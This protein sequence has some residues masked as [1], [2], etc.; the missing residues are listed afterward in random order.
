MT[1][2]TKK[3]VQKQVD[4]LTKQVGDLTKRRGELAG[5]RSKAQESYEQRMRLM[6]S[7]ALSGK[8]SGG[9]PEALIRDRVSI[10]TLDEA[11]NQAD[12]KLSELNQELADKKAALV[13]YDFR[14]VAADAESQIC[15]TVRSLAD[16]LALVERVDAKYGELISIASGEI[17]RD[18]YRAIRDLSR[19]FPKENV[20]DF[21][22]MIQAAYPA[23]YAQAQVKR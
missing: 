20:A 11:I 10:E 1:D 2:F 4:D 16:Y 7:D 19:A 22:R 18:E 8:S 3:D 13:L 15:N 12:Q 6:G 17:A 5:D 9:T 14:A 21:M 23:I